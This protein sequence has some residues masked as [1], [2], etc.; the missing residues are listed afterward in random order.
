MDLNAVK[1]YCRIDIEDDDALVEQLMTAAQKLI[2]STTGKTKYVD[3]DIKDNELYN[4]CV[5][6]LVAHWYNNR[7]IT[8]VSSTKELASIPYSVELIMRHI[9]MCGDYT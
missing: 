5:C 8:R 4:L 1:T 9:A 7:G 6:Q 2:D 3:T